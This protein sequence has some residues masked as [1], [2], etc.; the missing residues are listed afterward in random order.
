[1]GYMEKTQTS[2]RISGGMFAPEAEA[3]KIMTEIN[4]RLG[5]WGFGCEVNYR[6]D[7]DSENETWVS[8]NVYCDAEPGCIN[9]LTRRGFEALVKD[10][11]KD[12]G[13]RNDD[14]DEAD[15]EDTRV[16]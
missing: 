7:P 4:T 2:R 13:I 11:I 10:V 9:E 6:A 16:L 8:F 14:L 12:A 5:S 3:E 15:F 1:M